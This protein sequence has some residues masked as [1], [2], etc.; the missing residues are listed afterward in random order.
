MM[1]AI[2]LSSGV[3]DCCDS[4]KQESMMLAVV[5]SRDPC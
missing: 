1:I 3:H 5:L 4:A 2:V